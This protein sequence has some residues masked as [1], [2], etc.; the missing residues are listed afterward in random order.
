MVSLVE[1]TIL[2]IGAGTRRFIGHRLKR[3]FAFNVLKGEEVTFMRLDQ[4]LVELRR[5]L[6]S[7]LIT[8]IDVLRWG[9]LTRHVWRG[10]IQHGLGSRTKVQRTRLR[11]HENVI[12][13]TVCRDC[14]IFNE[15]QARLKL[16]CHL[17]L[18]KNIYRLSPLKSS[19]EKAP[20]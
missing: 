9:S 6:R 5:R 3:E 1:Q 13:R 12:R 16:I 8:R 14:W 2:K 11:V 17:L 10:T 15:R 4:E 20:S 19:P 18:D 7:E